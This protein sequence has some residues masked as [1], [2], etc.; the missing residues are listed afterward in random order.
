MLG[1]HYNTQGKKFNVIILAGGNGTRM[2]V[3]SDYIPK[4]LTELGNQRAIDHIITKFAMVAHKYIIGIGHHASLLRFYVTSR[5]PHLNIEFSEEAPEELQNNAL[6]TIYC[7]DHADS[8]YGTIITFCDLIVLDNP[9][10]VGDQLFYVDKDTEGHVGTFR[11]SIGNEIVS[12]SKP[13]LITEIPNGLLGLFAF[14]NTFELKKYAYWA[15]GEKLYDLTD[16]IIKWYYYF[17][18]MKSVRIKKV[19]EFG[20]AN[21]LMEVRKLWEKT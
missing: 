19:F 14:T 5:Y 3:A 15:V 2:G 20:T 4:A 10:I 13:K 6:S 11:H 9:E 18:S 12:Y 21:D 16:N 8:R 1:Q 7:L 17:N